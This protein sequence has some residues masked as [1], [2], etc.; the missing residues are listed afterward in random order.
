MQP[1]LSAPVIRK[2]LAAGSA[3][4]KVA[5]EA[6]STGS[7]PPTVSVGSTSARVVVGAIELVVVLTIRSGEDRN[8]SA[9]RLA[10]RSTPAP[11]KL[12]VITSTLTPSTIRCPR[13][14]R[15]RNGLPDDGVTPPGTAAVSPVLPTPLSLP[16]FATGRQGRRIR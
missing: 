11:T 14:W 16:A 8:D 4:G 9:V 3:A 7:V 2:F 5:T 10:T 1:L 15:R 6:V 12:D 13:E